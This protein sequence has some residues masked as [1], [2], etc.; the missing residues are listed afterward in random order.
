MATAKAKDLR[1]RRLTQGEKTKLDSWIREAI[2]KA[3]DREVEYSTILSVQDAAIKALEENLKR[4]GDAD[5]SS[6]S[7][8]SQKTERR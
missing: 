7:S 8:Y 2:E 6:N 4:E 1:E 3:L 5:P